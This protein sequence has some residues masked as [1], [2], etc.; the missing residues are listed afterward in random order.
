MPSVPAEV[1]KRQ[2]QYKKRLRP[3]GSLMP[4]LEPRSNFIRY[5]EHDHTGAEDRPVANFKHQL[6]PTNNEEI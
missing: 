2:A 4:N 1:A 6:I 5:T 3:D